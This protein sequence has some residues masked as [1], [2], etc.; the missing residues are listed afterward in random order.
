[1]RSWHAV[2]HAL[3]E[4][5]VLP[6][7]LHYEHERR[8]FHEMEPHAASHRNHHGRLGS[9]DSG[10]ATGRSQAG[11]ARLSLDSGCDPD[12]AC[13]GGTRAGNSQFTGERFCAAERVA[14]DVL[15]VP[16]VSAYLRGHD[17][18]VDV[19]EEWVAVALLPSSSA[20]WRL[21]A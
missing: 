17:R 20:L 13:N 3:V 9:R 7:L 15:V 16:L 8:N 2:P 1:M 4:R 6:A 14:Q 18:V 5:D 12:A 10:D 19:C 21:A 11:A